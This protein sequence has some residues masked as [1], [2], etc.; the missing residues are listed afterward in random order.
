MGFLKWL[1][2][3]FDDEISH[4]PVKRFCKY[5]DNYKPNLRQPKK[6]GPYCYADS[7][8]K[9]KKN[10]IEPLY[11]SNV[12]CATKN[13]NNDNEHSRNMWRAAQRRLLASSDSYR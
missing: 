7:V 3:D 11:V 5:C 8:A 1:E 4:W 6:G 13:A 10:A 9:E 12:R 2:R